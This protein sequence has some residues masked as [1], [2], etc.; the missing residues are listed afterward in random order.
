[1]KLSA[2]PSADP[3]HGGIMCR[4]SMGPCFGNKRYFDLQ[5]PNAGEGNDYLRHGTTAFICP[6]N[7]AVT[8]TPEK[9]FIIGELEIFKI[10]F[11]S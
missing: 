3:D 4:T 10:S 11:E 1:M 2:K 9:E 6:S 7:V 8:F 5:L